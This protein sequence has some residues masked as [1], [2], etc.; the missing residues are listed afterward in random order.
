MTNEEVDEATASDAP[1]TKERNTG[2]HPRQALQPAPDATWHELM[3]D[4]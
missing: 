3:E 4:A 2:Y 1:L